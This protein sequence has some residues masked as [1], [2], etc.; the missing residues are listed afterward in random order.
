MTRF[1]RTWPGHAAAPG[2]L[3]AIPATCRK[4]DGLPLTI[5]AAASRVRMLSGSMLAAPARGARRR[6]VAARHRSMNDTLDSRFHMLTD[7][8]QGLWRRLTAFAGGFTLTEDARGVDMRQQER[9]AC[10]VRALECHDRVGDLELCDAAGREGV[11]VGVIGDDVDR[12]GAAV[13]EEGLGVGAD[14]GRDVIPLYPTIPGTLVQ[15]SSV[16]IKPV[17]DHDCEHRR[18]RQV[19]LSLDGPLVP[20]IL[21]ETGAGALVAPPRHIRRPSSVRPK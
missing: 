2:R 9:G 14:Q 5:E 15:S 20:S 8:E 16:V 17:L 6:S 10:C 13:G 18:L 21:C 11:G 7:T 4:V 12:G 1:T 19:R 3:P